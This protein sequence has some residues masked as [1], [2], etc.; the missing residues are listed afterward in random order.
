MAVIVPILKQEEFD[1]FKDDAGELIRRL[2]ENYRSIMTADP[3]Q[4]LPGLTTEQNVLLAF[5][6]WDGQVRNGG[7]IQLIEN[8]YGSFI[9]DTPVA[10]HL[11]AWGLER[12]ASIIDSGRELYRA[13]REILEREKT[14][15]EFALL[16]QEHPE[17][18]PMD[19][20]YD[21]ICDEERRKVAQYVKAHL[22]LFVRII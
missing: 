8:G 1:A 19:K 9:F 22:P 15:Q 7:V 18:E 10:G 5:E 14:L 13:K 11:R 2:C 16:Y 17:F 4:Q 3:S 21:V 12:T 6:A 20:E